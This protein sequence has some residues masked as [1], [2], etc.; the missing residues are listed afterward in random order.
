MFLLFQLIY[1]IRYQENMVSPKCGKIFTSKVKIQLKRN[2]SYNVYAFY[3]CGRH[4]QFLSDTFNTYLYLAI[5]LYSLFHS[6]FFFNKIIKCF[7]K[8]L[9]QNEFNDI[10]SST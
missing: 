3:G 7:Q 5:F 9:G 4:T 6:L 10:D 2:R 8:D 1:F